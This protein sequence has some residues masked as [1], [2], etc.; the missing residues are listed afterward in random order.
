MSESRLDTIE[1]SIE[2]RTNSNESIDLTNY[3]EVGHTHEI[4]DVNNL[5]AK[6]T[7][8]SVID[9]THE[10]TGITDFKSAIIDLVYTVGLIYPSMDPTSPA[11]K[12]GDTWG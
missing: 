8:Y 10:S 6:L 9:H 12:F 5:E 3:S 11:T 2:N 1:Q 4:T 7:N